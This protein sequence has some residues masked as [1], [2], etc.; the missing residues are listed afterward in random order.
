VPRQLLDLNQLKSEIRERKDK[1]KGK[2]LIIL[3][4]FKEYN[5]IDLIGF[6]LSHKG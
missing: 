2:R 4:I 6:I 5:N 1:N 3:T